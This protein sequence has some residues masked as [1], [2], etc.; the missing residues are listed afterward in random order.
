MSDHWNFYIAKVDHKVASIMVDLGIKSQTPIITHPHM[1]YLR[2]YLQHSNENGLSSDV[3]FNKLCEIGDKIEANITPQNHLYVGRNTSNGTRDFFF[4]THDYDKL[5]ASIVQVMNSFADYEYEIGGR[6]DGKWL[7]Y[8]EFLYPDPIAY[9]TMMNRDVCEALKKNGDN[10]EV[11]RL[12]DHRAYFKKKSQRLNFE[13]FLS[14]Q[15][16]LIK[17]IG[18]I[19][20]IIGDYFIDFERADI[21]IEIDNVIMPLFEKIEELQGTYDGWGCTVRPSITQ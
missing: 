3:E 13:K 1:G 12:I 8:K 17:N 7:T 11:E 2:L 6:E 15:G 16:F 18:R 21:Q 4:Y 14:A 9:Q 20:P 19:K 5:H 10:L